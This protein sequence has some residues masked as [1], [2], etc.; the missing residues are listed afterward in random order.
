MS[1][2]SPGRVLF[3]PKLR[4]RPLNTQIHQRDFPSFSMGSGKTGSGR[5][6]KLIAMA[7]QT[8]IKELQGQGFGPSA[9]AVR[10]SV[11][12]K[13]LRNY[14]AQEDYSP[15][16]PVV[17]QPG[18]SKRD[19]YVPV[20]HQWLAAPFPSALV[21]LGVPRDRWV[22]SFGPLAT[23]YGPVMVRYGVAQ[24]CTTDRCGLW[25]A[26][27][28][29]GVAAPAGSAVFYRREAG[30]PQGLRFGQVQSITDASSTSFVSCYRVRSPKP[31]RGG[32][33][34][35]CSQAAIRAKGRRIPGQRQGAG[36]RCALRV[37]LTR[38]PP[39]DRTRGSLEPVQDGT[40][41]STHQ[42]AAH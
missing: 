13:T 7:Q 35:R 21:S 33:R 28:K 9:M 40:C 3:S 10:L 31:N 4:Q 25:P 34:V 11:D 22:A 12:R 15:P 18:P 39:L 32:N 24:A 19:P 30:T 36:R 20:I 37:H 38:G 16:P 2:P 8:P 42:P 29:T 1:L 14:L 26:P 6:V 27:F 23:L 5:T 17:W 41:L